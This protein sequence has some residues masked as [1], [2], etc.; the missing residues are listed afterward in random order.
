MLTIT[1]NFV[2]LVHFSN[3]QDFDMFLVVVPDSWIE[4][5]TFMKHNIQDQHCNA[6]ED[7]YYEGERLKRAG[8]Y[9]RNVVSISTSI[10]MLIQ[11]E[12]HKLRETL[13]KAGVYD[14]NAV[15]ISTS[16]SILVQIEKHILR[17]TLKTKKTVC[18]VISP[19]L[20]S[21]F[22]SLYYN[23]TSLFYTFSIKIFLYII[24]SHLLYLLL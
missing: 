14:R 22:Q 4:I 11:I 23:Y 7:L 2:L 15:S 17:E 20:A 19:D 3:E 18:Y 9:D 1:I 8:M 10:S 6:L 13:K 12:K 16:M 5:T 24:F 21:Q